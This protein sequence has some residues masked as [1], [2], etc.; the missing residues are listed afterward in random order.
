MHE[1]TLVF[2]IIFVTTSVAAGLVLCARHFLKMRERLAPEVVFPKE[3]TFGMP[4]Q[5]QNS[6][7]LAA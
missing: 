3:T 6:H 5:P 2:M 1:L 4:A 7:R